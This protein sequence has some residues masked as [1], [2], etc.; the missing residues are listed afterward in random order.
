MKRT[1]A[2]LALLAALTTTAVLACST[3]RTPTGT[4]P[5]P[6][7]SLSKADYDLDG[8][9][10]LSEA[11]KAAKKAAHEAA[12]QQRRLEKE[13]FDQAM[14]DWKAY[15]RAV[16]DNRIT[17]EL[18]RCEPQQ[19]AVV[20]KTIGPKGG[21]IRVGRHRLVIPEGALGANVE[22]TA[23][24]PAGALVKV[25]FEPH[26][27]QFAKPVTVGLSYEHCILPVDYVGTVVYLGNG[28]QIADYQPSD[29]DADAKEVS[30]LTDHF[31]GYA[32]ATRK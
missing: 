12:E 24:Q 2:G 25:E 17:A 22:I 31:S 28:N 7:Q 1:R 10:R 11:E 32:V 26:G 6:G 16:K 15:K 4:T 8:D 21:E 29:D 18:L 20:A 13:E 30:G 27:L 5:A 3:D 19:R 23:T 14:K 9:G